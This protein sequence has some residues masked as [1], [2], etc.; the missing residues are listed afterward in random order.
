MTYPTACHPTDCGAPCWGPTSTISKMD[1]EALLHQF[2]GREWT[3]QTEAVPALTT[4][5]ALI[6][7]ADPDAANTPAAST[8]TAALATPAIPSTSTT[9]Y[10]GHLSNPSNTWRERPERTIPASARCS[11]GA[12]H[13]LQ[14]SRAAQ[15]SLPKRSSSDQQGTAGQLQQGWLHCV[16]SEL[17]QNHRTVW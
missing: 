8:S 5:P 11:R 13:R 4:A 14:S 3:P 7:S 16:S 2:A 9:D 6:A 17:R 15:R 12:I 1:V 10:Y